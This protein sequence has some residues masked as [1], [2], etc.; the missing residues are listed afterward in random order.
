MKYKPLD[1][2]DYCCVPTSII[3]ILERRK[4][5]HGSQEEVGYELGLVVPKAAAHK[6][7]KV[8]VKSKPGAGYG[9]Q[10]AK[11]PYSINNFFRKYNINLI[12]EYIFTYNIEEAR[13]IIEENLKQNNDIIT[14]FNSKA[15]HGE[16]DYGH[17][18]LIESIEGDM[19]TLVDPAK[20]VPKRIKVKLDKL[21]KAIEIHGKKN[22]AG[23]WVIKEK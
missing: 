16:G 14:C 23:F 3:M 13:K 15:L 5:P 18:S 11:K 20:N 22:Q 6:F 10:V 17:V 1:Q 19:I 12:E 21:V 9:T 7:K 8:R 4:I 2:I